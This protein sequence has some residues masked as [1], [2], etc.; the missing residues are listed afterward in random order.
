MGA[1]ETGRGTAVR[2][3]GEGTHADLRGQA[4]IRGPC[5]SVRAP[6]PRYGT[7]PSVTRTST[8]IHSPCS[9]SRASS[10]ARCSR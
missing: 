10:C 2:A 5:L 7:R 8:S 9:V 3:R 4:F 1:R 6:L